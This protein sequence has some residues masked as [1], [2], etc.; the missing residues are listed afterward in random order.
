MAKAKKVTKKRTKN[1]IK[2]KPIATKK[3]VVAKNPRAVV[4]RKTEAG[5]FIPGVFHVFAEN[6]NG[7]GYLSSLKPTFDSDERKAL[8]MDKQIGDELA[9]N[10]RKKYR[11]AKF[12]LVRVKK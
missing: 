5:Y 10:L 2:K 12:S 4:K 6:K 3:R 8:V 7:T 11:S 1:P 9:K